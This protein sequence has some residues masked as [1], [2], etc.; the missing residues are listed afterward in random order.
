MK[1]KREKKKGGRRRQRGAEG[2]LFKVIWWCC[3]CFSISL[4]GF[5]PGLV[6]LRHTGPI[7]TY[8]YFLRSLD[9]TKKKRQSDITGG[10]K[11]SVFCAVLV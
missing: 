7:H 11:R 8:P 5:V 6:Q 4:L 3:F 9:K 2:G 1:G 10:K